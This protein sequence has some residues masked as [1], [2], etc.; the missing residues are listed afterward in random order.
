MLS[1]FGPVPASQSGIALVGL[2]TLF[3]YTAFIVLGMIAAM[4]VNLANREP[5]ILLGFVVLFAATEVGFYAFVGLLPPER[6]A[7]HK[8]WLTRWTS[9]SRLDWTLFRTDRHRRPRRC[10]RPFRMG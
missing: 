6:A 9:S 2:Y 7:P 8:E 5:S 10:W 3:H 1:I 4:I